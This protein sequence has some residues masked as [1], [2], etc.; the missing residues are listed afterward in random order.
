MV[1]P[2]CAQCDAQGSGQRQDPA[3]RSDGVQRE[4][5]AE[6]AAD[7]E[8][9]R[10]PRRR[11]RTAQGVDTGV[12]HRLRAPVE[13][14]GG[15]PR[16]CCCA[17]GGF[18]PRT[19]LGAGRCR[20]KNRDYRT[21][22]RRKVDAAEAAPWSATARRGPGKPGRQ[23]R[24]WRDRPGPCRLLGSRAT[25]RPF[26]AVGA[27]LVDRRC[28]HPARQIRAARRPCRTCSRGTVS[29]GA[30]PRRPCAASG[31]RHQRA[32]SR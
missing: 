27:V 1:E 20:R 31:S 17:A 10:P 24:H 4:A 6:G 30:H 29:R 7:G 5:G 12:H 23:C 13:F 3:T 8:P 18:R 21:Q 28:A 16:Q 25:R 26:R 2:G 11:R 15:H 9:D 14:G 19:G 32:G 22:R